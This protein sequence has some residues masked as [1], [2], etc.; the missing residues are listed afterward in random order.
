MKGTLNERMDAI[1]LLV[2]EHTE[3]MDAIELLV[4][5]QADLGLHGRVYMLE[6]RLHRL[7]GDR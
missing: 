3:R 5:E 4:K 2:L 7:D 6:E 1:E